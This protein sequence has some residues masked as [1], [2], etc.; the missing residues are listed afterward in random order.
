MYWIQNEHNIKV[1]IVPR[2]RGGDW[3]ADELRVFR[4]A[5]I[6]VVVSLLTETEVGEL[7]LEH[8]QE[9]CQAAGIS[10][11][12]FP[13]PDRAVP[14]SRQSFRILI[15][16]LKQELHAGRSVGIHCR[17]CIGRSSVLAAALLCSFG[18]SADAAFAQIEQSRGCPVPDTKEQ[19]EWVRRF[20]DQKSI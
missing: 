16:R 8:E 14:A 18:S 9:A 4:H 7:G 10:F 11:I 13:I 3:L 20:G 15:D 19:R 5:G 12:E 17:Q 6:D 2:P 1:A